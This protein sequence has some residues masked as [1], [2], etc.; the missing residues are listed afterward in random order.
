MLLDLAQPASLS[1]GHIVV[2]APAASGPGDGGGERKAGFS[3]TR[4]RGNAFMILLFFL[5]FLTV[6]CVRNYAGVSSGSTDAHRRLKIK[7]LRT[8]KKKKKNLRLGSGADHL[9]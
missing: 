6:Q 5:F 4:R 8:K 2:E 9:V 7:D 3:K 1:S